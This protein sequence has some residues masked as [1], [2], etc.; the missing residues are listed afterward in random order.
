MELSELTAYAG[1][2]FHMREQRKWADFPGFSVLAD[3]HTGKWVALLMRQWDFDTGME[4]QRCDLK[5]GRQVLSERPE[6]Y[7]SLPFRMR[8]KEWVGVIFDGSTEP[9][10]IFRLFDR[11]VYAAEERGYTIV[12]DTPPTKPVVVYPETALPAAGTSFTAAI[13]D[14]PERI[15]GMLRLYE[16]EDNSFSRK[17]GNFYRQGKFMEE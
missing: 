11:A 4:I 1:E 13:P 17:C 6:P 3:P 16:R 15:R 14:V 5:C 8:G 12:L 2:K 9:D 10:A 7:L